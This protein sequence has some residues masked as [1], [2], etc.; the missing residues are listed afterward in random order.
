MRINFSDGSYVIVRLHEIGTI[1]QMA[2]AL[3]VTR[4]A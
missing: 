3:G 1:E 2:A 4:A